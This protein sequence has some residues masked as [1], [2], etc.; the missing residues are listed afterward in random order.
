MASMRAKNDPDGRGSMVSGFRENGVG[1]RGNGCGARLAGVTGQGTG[2]RPGYVGVAGRG[3]RLR[4]VLC[5]RDGTGDG[6]TTGALRIVRVCEE[7]HR[8][9]SLRSLTAFFFDR[10][11]MGTLGLCPKPH[12]GRRP[13]TPQG[14]SSL[15]P[16]SLRAGLSGFITLRASAGSRACRSHPRGK[17]PPAPSDSASGTRP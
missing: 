17:S 6:V 1:R 16:S 7:S 14:I 5:G 9:V 4:P 13:L 12:K 10:F 11:A 2:L 15:D 3:T 8:Q